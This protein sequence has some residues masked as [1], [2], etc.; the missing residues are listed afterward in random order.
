MS[1]TYAAVLCLLGLVV[2]YVC[3]TGTIREKTVKVAFAMFWVALFVW[4]LAIGHEPIT[5]WR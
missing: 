5:F 3:A 1:S 4:L 2:Y